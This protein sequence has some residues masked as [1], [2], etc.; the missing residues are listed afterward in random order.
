MPDLPRV[1]LS[2]TKKDLVQHRIAAKNAIID[3]GCHPVTM[4]HFPAEDGAPLDVC[5]REVES[6]AALVVL[7]AHRYGWI[8]EAQAEPKTKSI[9]W[10]ECEHAVAKRIPVFALLLDSKHD[11]PAADRDSTQAIAALERGETPSIA[12]G[13]LAKV[14]AWLNDGRVTAAFT[15]PESVHLEVLKALHQWRNTKPA[16]ASVTSARYVAYLREAM[17]WID[18]RGLQV[19][20]G[21]A[22]RFEIEQLYVPVKTAS[23]ELRGGSEPKSMPL[24]QALSAKRLVIQGDAGSGKTTFLRRVARE[25]VRETGP[26]A[27]LPVRGLP[28]FVR[29]F[30]LDAHIREFEGKPGTPARHEPARWIAHYFASGGWGLSES[31][32]QAQLEQ[33]KALLL[34]DGLDEAPN[35]ERRHFMA[36]LF[37]DATRRFPEARF[38]VTTRPAAYQGRSVLA[39]FEVATIEPL[40]D[41]AVTAFLRLWSKC[42]F[43]SNEAGAVAHRAELERA[44]AE[45]PEIR[46][47][48]R[49]PVMLTALAVVHW[50]DKRLPEQRAELY[51]S[52]V[53]WL[54]EQREKKPG[55]EPA[56][57]CLNA[58]SELALSMQDDAKGRQVEI[59]RS[60]AEARMEKSNPGAEFLDR[61]LVDSGI[62]VSRGNKLRFWHLTFQE[63]LAARRLGAMADYESL[64]F[65]AE[66]TPLFSSEWRETVL[67]LGGV[68]GQDGCDED[69]RLLALLRRIGQEPKTFADEVRCVALLSAMLHDLKP[70]GF[71]L[72][73]DWYRDLVASM[74]RLF[75]EGGADEVDIRDRAA[76]G[77]ALP[78]E[79]HPLLRTPDQ[80]EYWVKIPGG[81][82]RTG[83][84]EI[85]KRDRNWPAPE[86]MQTVAEFEIGRL[87][88]TVQEYAKFVEESG[89]QPDEWRAQ[90]EH[91]SRPV[92]NVLKAHVDGY[93]EW[94]K[95]KLGR[96]CRL[97]TEIEWEFA[98]RGA[99]S[100]KYAWGNP[101]PDAT[102]CNIDRW[103]GSASPAGLFPA[104]RT[105]EGVCDMTGN[106]W[107][108]TS[109][110]HEKYSGAFVIRGGSWSS[111]R[112]VAACAFRVCGYPDDLNDGLGFRVART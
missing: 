111:S 67:L 26:L 98:A 94:V 37:E 106:V 43:P 20:S 1:F 59:P 22:H 2:A 77:D 10:L 109:S 68:L 105:P 90:L 89:L 19:G 73:E 64:L 112:V 34:V 108:W 44:L 62:V 76:A 42:L 5:L 30:D 13:Q 101:E 12:V 58:L 4:E 45:K 53:K 57:V 15:N 103:I 46:E 8:P 69:S 27:D 25:L 107:E 36:D 38:L 65:R 50:N 9:T 39:G 48:A 40:D 74:G 35:E 21:K 66:R 92:V 56:K 79:L 75:T 18:L 17:R 104:G 99:D 110:P 7:V 82:F 96:E 23:R 81:R 95:R 97:P 78:V 84:N 6:C 16:Q 93:C 52:V 47:M 100:R 72:D 55:R 54:A 91:R 63:Y 80:D 28:L 24:E 60:G 49:N 3:A 71:V 87:P 41:E 83:D 85:A 29:I 31:Y 70:A 102:R 32:L 86:S 14:K 33:G 61:E 11:W 51:Q 88:V